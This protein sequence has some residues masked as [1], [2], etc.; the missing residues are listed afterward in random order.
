MNEQG[1]LI[2]PGETVSRTRGDVSTGRQARVSGTVRAQAADAIREVKAHIKREIKYRKGIVGLGKASWIQILRELQIPPANM[3]GLAK[4][5][6]MVLPAEALA[7]VYGRE[8]TTGRDQFNITVSSRAQTALNP[9]A[10]GIPAFARSINGKVKE[11]RKATE[12][13]LETYVR[14]FADRHG[15]TVQSR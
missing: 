3:R 5:S 8:A 7:A 6:K 9:R 13:D 2:K 14:R 1:E 10:G 15:F 11:F 4:A 12:K